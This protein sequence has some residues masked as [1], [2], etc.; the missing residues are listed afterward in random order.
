[1]H[2]HLEFPRKLISYVMGLLLS[3]QLFLFQQGRGRHLGPYPSLDQGF[4]RRSS[5]SSRIARLTSQ[6][7]GSLVILDRLVVSFQHGIHGLHWIGRPYVL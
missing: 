2:F 4:L 7:A 5:S 3:Q 6:L 1:M